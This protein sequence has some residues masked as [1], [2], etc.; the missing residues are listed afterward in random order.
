MSTYDQIVQLY[1]FGVLQTVSLSERIFRAGR[2]ATAFITQA[3]AN[4]CA[5]PAPKKMYDWQIP[6][7]AA[8]PQKD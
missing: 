3:L 2:H 1:A 4:A 6:I 8:L 5:I 7:E